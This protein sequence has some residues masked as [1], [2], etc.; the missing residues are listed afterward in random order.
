ME[1]P[2]EKEQSGKVYS[3]YDYLK[4]KQDNNDRDRLYT[5]GRRAYMWQ[6]REYTNRLAAQE[7]GRC[8]GC[9]YQFPLLGDEDE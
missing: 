5:I 3:L 1:L 4:A 6:Y 8:Y 2:L 9:G 7:G